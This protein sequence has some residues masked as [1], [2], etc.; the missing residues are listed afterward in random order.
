MITNGGAI[1]AEHAGNKFLISL[2]KAARV[3]RW[4]ACPLMPELHE[5]LKENPERRPD[6]DPYSCSREREVAGMNACA[7]L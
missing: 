3:L 2:Q 4:L 5:H 7:S 1:P 6:P